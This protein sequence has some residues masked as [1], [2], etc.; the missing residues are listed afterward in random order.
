MGAWGNMPVDFQ[1]IISNWLLLAAAG[2]DSNLAFGIDM[3]IE[4][5]RSQQYSYYIFGFLIVSL[6][7]FSVI[8]LLYMPKKGASLKRGEKI[9]FG[10]IISGVIIA[11]FFGWLQLVEGYLL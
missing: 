8:I 4:N 2:N 11:V 7:I 3:S 5:L 10:A 9:M 6:V 1:A